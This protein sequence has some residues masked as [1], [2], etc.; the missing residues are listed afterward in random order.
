MIIKN[1]IT[2]IF[3]YFLGFFFGRFMMTFTSVDLSF[4]RFLAEFTLS[5]IRNLVV[6]F[7]DGYVKDNIYKYEK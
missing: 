4:W 6:S 1:I 2:I 3:I 5:L 7:S